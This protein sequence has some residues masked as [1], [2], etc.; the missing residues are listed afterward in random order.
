MHNRVVGLPVGVIRFSAC[1]S[2][3]VPPL[4]RLLPGYLPLGLSASWPL[5]SRTLRLSDSC[6][7][8]SHLLDSCLLRVA[9]LR[10]VVVKLWVSGSWV[11]GRG[12][13]GRGSSVV[14]LWVQ[15]GWGLGHLYLEKSR[16]G[17]DRHDRLLV[18]KKN[19]QL[20]SL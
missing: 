5:A 6:L 20:V 10:V 4:G 18:L 19:P 1:G 13:L 9:G 12:S 3:N 15:G 11:F 14:G 17:G 8:A 16:T 2:Q 7:L